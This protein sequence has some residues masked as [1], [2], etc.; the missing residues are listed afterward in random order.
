MSVNLPVIEKVAGKVLLVSK[1]IAPVKVRCANE[2]I[3]SQII[4]QMR[5]LSITLG[6]NLN[7]TV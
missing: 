1:G 5:K 6:K 4:D 7:K 2:N 3:A